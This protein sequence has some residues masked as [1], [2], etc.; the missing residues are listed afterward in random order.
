MTD[1]LAAVRAERER[2][3]AEEGWSPEHDDAHVVHDWVSLMVRYL[4]RAMDAAEE[5]NPDRYRARLVQV[6]AIAVAAAESLD[7]VLGDA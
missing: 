6:A 3:Q 2:Q 7:R 5:H 1:V 4:G